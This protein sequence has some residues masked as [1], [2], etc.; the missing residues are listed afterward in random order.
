MKRSDDY[1]CRNCKNKLRE[2]G[3]EPGAQP[4]EDWILPLN[5]S[6]RL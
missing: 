1:N 6:R 4:W 2:P 3:I 5:H